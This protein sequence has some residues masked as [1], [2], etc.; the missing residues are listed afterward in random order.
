MIQSSM[1]KSITSRRSSATE[2]KCRT[3]A[4][5]PAT[6]NTPTPNWYAPLLTLVRQDRFAEGL[7]GRYARNGYLDRCLFHLKE[8]DENQAQGVTL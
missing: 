3:G 4:L 7:L 8:L 5:R 2:S 1:P 6:W